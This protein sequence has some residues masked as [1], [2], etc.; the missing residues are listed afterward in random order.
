MHE[1]VELGLRNGTTPA[2]VATAKGLID[3]LLRLFLTHAPAAER[4]DQAGF[5]ETLTALRGDVDAADH[6]QEVRRLGAHALRACGKFLETARRYSAAREQE[7]A[8]TIDI[9]HETARR[10]V[11]DD[12]VHD[13]LRAASVRVGDLAQLDDIRRLKQQLAEEAAR[14]ERAADARQ[15]RDE[16]VLLALAREVEALHARLSQAEEE[17]AIDPVTKVANRGA[18][19]R[20]LDRLTRAARASGRPLT[21]V[22][23]D[24]DR[25]KQINDTHGHPVGDRVLLCAA[26]W[27]GAAIRKTDLVARLGGDEFAAILTESDLAGAEARVRDI[28]ARVAARTFDYEADDGRRTVQFTLS[29]GLA[30]VGASESDADLLRRADQAL[31]E[32]KA[33]GRNCAVAKKRSRLA[34]LFS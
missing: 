17:A 29:A 6:D 10:A 20:A 25:F 14:L 16:A 5:H 8:E 31:Y 33:L 23:L 24:V 28:L 18:F 13:E 21:I 27:I 11:G 34:S 30:E 19:E 12:G 26:Q 32:A 9:L 7:L 1:I 2:Q 3:G 4:R 22:L 15:K